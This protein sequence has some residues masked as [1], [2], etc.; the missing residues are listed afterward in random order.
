MT[1]GLE[2]R[3]LITSDGRLL[4]E[5]LVKIDPDKRLSD[6]L[7]ILSQL[8]PFNLDPIQISGIPGPERDRMEC[9]AVETSAIGD[10]IKDGGYFDRGRYIVATGAA[11]YALEGAGINV[12]VPDI[13]DALRATLNEPHVIFFH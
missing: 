5:P 8:P 1:G 10:A 4:N 7:R 11:A 2:I 13:Q 12:S 9:I 3:P 6:S